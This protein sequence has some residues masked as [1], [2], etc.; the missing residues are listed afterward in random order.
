MKIEIENLIEKFYYIPKDSDIKEP[1]KPL[2][3]YIPKILTDPLRNLLN[4]LNSENLSQKDLVEKLGLSKGLISR[5]LKELRERG[6]INTSNRKRGKE[7]FFELTTKG[8]WYL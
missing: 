8:R 4:I 2:E 6:L 1:V 5:Y 7:R 3:I